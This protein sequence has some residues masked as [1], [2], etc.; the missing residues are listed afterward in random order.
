[1]IDEN[2]LDGMV[3]KFLDQ[4][5]KDTEIK[6]VNDSDVVYGPDGYEE[7]IKLDAVIYYEGEFDQD[8]F[9]FK[10]YRE[11]YWSDKTEAGKLRRSLSP[12]L[13]VDDDI[14]ESLDS[15][16]NDNWKSGFKKWFKHNFDE[17]INTIR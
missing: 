5:F 8:V 7:K 1:M 13:A 11:N 2:K 12:I 10:L 17:D 14:K 16:F 4:Y 9:I 3:I 6:K 15:L